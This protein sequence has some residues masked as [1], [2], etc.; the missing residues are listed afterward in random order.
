MSMP[1]AG[2]VA[3]IS[4]GAGDIGSAIAR[5]LAADGADV[6][7]GDVVSAAAVDSLAEH[8]RA[9]GR[10]FRYDVVDVSDA[11]AVERWVGDVEQAL[12]APRIVVAC[13]AIVHVTRL[14]DIAPD[15]WRRELAVN[16]DGAFH[17]AQAAGRRMIRAGGGGRIVLIGS[18]AAHAVQLHIPAYCVAKAGLRMLGRCLA[19]ELAPHG[20]AVNELAPGYVD[21]GLSARAFAEQPSLR[22]RAVKTVPLGRLITPDEVAAQVA[23]LCD[24]ANRHVTGSTILMDGGLSLIGPGTANTM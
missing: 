24:P 23:A 18:W 12:G 5:R 11:A 16:L 14:F 10:R 2:H 21:A 17:V 3:L 20:I 6:A 19:A 8:V 22:E 13:A 9:A 4:G 1:L 7:V 15:E